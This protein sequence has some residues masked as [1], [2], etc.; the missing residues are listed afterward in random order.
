MKTRKI[1][2]AVSVCLLFVGF[3]LLSTATAS[4][5]NEASGNVEVSSAGARLDVEFAIRETANSESGAGFFHYESTDRSTKLAAEVFYVKVDDEYAWFAG[6]CV[7]DRGD[8]AGR[9]FFAAVHDGGTPGSLADHIWW[10]WL[11]EGPGAEKTAKSKV[12][13][14]ERPVSN[15]PIKAG[16]IVV[17]LCQ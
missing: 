10:D 7:R 4:C 12:E 8:L 6:R 1:I 9:W 3:P 5:S 16:N 11:P 15:K 17:N 2:L 13:N 14:L